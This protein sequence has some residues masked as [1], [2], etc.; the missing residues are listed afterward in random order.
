MSRR[1]KVPEGLDRP[2]AS[3]LDDLARPASSVASLSGS[4]SATSGSPV[5]S[6]TISP[7]ATTAAF[8]VTPF[9][10]T[11]AQANSIPVAMNA[12]IARQALMITL[13]NTLLTDVV[14]NGT[15]LG[16]TVTTVNNILAAL[17]AS[18]KMDS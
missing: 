10:F 1:S 12:L 7:V 11:E 4:A 15:L 3:F 5:S 13:L 6:A 17:R 16:S 18:Q 14:A 8:D 9:G 2:L